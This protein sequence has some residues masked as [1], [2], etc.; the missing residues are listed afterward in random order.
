MEKVC[1]APA[2]VI[3]AAFAFVPTS[4][5]MP[6]TCGGDPDFPSS[7]TMNCLYAPHLR[8]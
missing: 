3:P 1:P 2:G 8:G 7:S 6:R 4:T 5:G